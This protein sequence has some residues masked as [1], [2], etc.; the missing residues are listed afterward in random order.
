MFNLKNDAILKRF[1]VIVFPLLAFIM[2]GLFGLQ[3]VN[4]QYD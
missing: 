3:S 2:P 4:A 1:L